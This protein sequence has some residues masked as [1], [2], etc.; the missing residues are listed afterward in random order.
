MPFFLGNGVR[1]PAPKGLGAFLFL[2]LQYSPMWKVKLDNNIWLAKGKYDPETTSKESEAWLL[3]S[4]PAVQEQL[5]KARSSNPYPN[6]MVIA[7][8]NHLE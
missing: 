6:A 7:D 3:P 2:L 5:K 4:M 1:L 8:F